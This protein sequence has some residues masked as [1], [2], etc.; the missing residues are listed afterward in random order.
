[1]KKRIGFTNKK[2]K[3]VI[4]VKVCNSFEKFLGL[5]FKEREKS[6]ALLFDF[7]KSK[8]IRIH[9]IFVFFSFVA[10]WIDDKNKIVDF[11]IV[12]PFSFIIFSRKFS[13]KLIEIPINKRYM[14]LVKLLVGD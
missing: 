9:S 14:N 12:K 3:F 5:M 7:K 1:M 2:R 8:K 6:Q 4:D 11:E 10:V 13:N